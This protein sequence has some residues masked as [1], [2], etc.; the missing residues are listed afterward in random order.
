MGVLVCVADRGERQ[1]AQK[2]SVNLHICHDFFAYFVQGGG[3]LRFS[4]ISE[5][6]QPILKLDS[7]ELVLHIES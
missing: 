7:G 1:F 6:K 3:W 2:S 4:R 5:A